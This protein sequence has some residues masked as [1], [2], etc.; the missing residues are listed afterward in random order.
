MRSNLVVV[1]PPDSDGVPGLWQRLEPMLIQAF[2]PELAVEALDVAVLHRAARLNQ[3]VTN[4]MGLRPG[5]E[6]AAGEFRSVVGSHCVRMSAKYSRLIQQPG[7]ILAAD[8]VVGRD[9]HALVAKIVGHGQ[10]LDAPAIGQAVAD[11]IHAPHLI[12]V[13]RDLQ[14]HAIAH[15]PFD[16]LALPDGQ[17]GG[18]VE[19][20][21]AL[22]VDLGKVRTQQIM[23]APV[24]KASSRLRNM[25]DR[26]TEHHCLLVRLRRVAVTTAG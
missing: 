9:V 12:D 10:A 17:L 11:K 13:V 18:A 21:H 25:D 5:H 15:R 14:R 3:N 16:L 23:D 22:V 2:I 24:A 19:P 26:G 6:S 8:A 1:L 4:A 20:I 7:H